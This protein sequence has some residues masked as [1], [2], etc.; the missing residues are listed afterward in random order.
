M[1][2]CDSRLPARYHCSLPPQC[3]NSLLFSG[4]QKLCPTSSLI[5]SLVLALPCPERSKM[6]IFFTLKQISPAFLVTSAKHRGWD[7]LPRD[8]FHAA[9]PRTVSPAFPPRY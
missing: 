4:P 7:P 5:F 1:M 6:P 3:A 8:F 2:V 9:C